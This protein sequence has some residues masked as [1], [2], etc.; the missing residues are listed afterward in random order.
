MQIFRNGFY[1][2]WE[3]IWWKPISPWSKF[4]KKITLVGDMMIHNLVKYLIQTR[5]H[6]W[7]IKIINNK[8]LV[9]NPQ[10]AF[11]LEPTKDGRKPPAPLRSSKSRM[12]TKAKRT[13]N[14]PA[15]R[16]ALDNLDDA[17]GSGPATA[18][19]VSSPFYCRHVG[20]SVCVFW[21][22]YSS[23]ISCGASMWIEIRFN[24]CCEF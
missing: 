9:A 4:N 22:F 23:S 6:L 2:I 5:L 24:L 17:G 18:T 1:F 21:N 15:K 20:S 8:S 19:G 14:P 13:R 10:S 16:R 11:A 3:H 12:K 7:D